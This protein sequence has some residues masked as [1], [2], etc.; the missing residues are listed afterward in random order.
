MHSAFSDLNDDI[1]S[2]I[3][4]C[5]SL[6]LSDKTCSEQVC[7]GWRAFLRYP[8]S[9]P[10]CSIWADKLIVSLTGPDVGVSVA[11]QGRHPKFRLSTAGDHGVQKQL[12][13]GRWVR[14]RQN[15]I[16]QLLLYVS[17]G[18][19][20]R[21]AALVQALHAKY[22]LANSG[23]E[24]QLHVGRDHFLGLHYMLNAACSCMSEQMTDSM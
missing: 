23:I 11:D 17:S 5:V 13:F 20:W 19:A 1:L 2:C 8:L 3:F 4:S 7:K 6:D 15:G 21:L 14:Q 22:K 18:G 9:K 16:N 12:C 24:V 10:A